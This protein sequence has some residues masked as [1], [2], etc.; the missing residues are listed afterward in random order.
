MIQIPT[1]TTVISSVNP[2]AYGQTVTFTA[3]VS[4]IPSIGN[5]TGTVTFYA[6][7]AVIGTGTLSTVDGVTTAMFFLLPGLIRDL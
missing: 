4:A 2:S 6:D 7:G 3:T 5:P 1:I